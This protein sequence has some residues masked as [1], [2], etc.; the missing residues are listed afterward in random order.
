VETQYKHL[1]LA[2]SESIND[3]DLQSLK[4]PLIVSPKVD[5][6]RCGVQGGAPLTRT[7]KPIPNIYVR[8]VLTQLVADFDGE[9]AVGQLTSPT[10]MQDTMSGVMTRIGAPNFTFNVFDRI[11]LGRFPFEKRL[12]ELQDQ[13]RG[14]EWPNWLRLMEHQWCDTLEELVEH[15]RQWREQGYEGMMIRAPRAPYE[16]RRCSKTE[17]VFLKFKRWEYAEAEVLELVEGRTN[18]NTAFKDERGYTKRSTV[19]SGMVPSGTLGAMRVRD[20]KT[21]KIAH[22]STGSLTKTQLKYYWEN[23]HLLMGKIVTYKFQRIGTVNLPRFPGFVSIRH[24]D[25]LSRY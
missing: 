18:T 21:Q 25:D 7:L 3:E 23:Q 4:F 17:A 19:K 8:G 5:G 9:L 13:I 1:M 22:L 6:I 11:D 15:E 20:L 24:P 16:H 10:L 12:Q 2:P 14:S